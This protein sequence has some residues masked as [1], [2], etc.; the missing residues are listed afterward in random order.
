MKYV[1][2]DVHVKTAVWCCLDE[3]GTIVERGKTPTTPPELTK[4]AARLQE[5]EPVLLG[6]RTSYAAYL[7]KP[8]TCSCGNATSRGLC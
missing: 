3:S 1:G 2:L 6:R 4:L 5:D 7:F 8:G